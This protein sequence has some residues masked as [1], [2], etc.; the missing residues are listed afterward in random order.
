MPSLLSRPRSRL[1]VPTKVATNAGR[2]HAVDLTGGG[3]LLEPAGV[4]HADPVGHRERLGLVVGDEQG[5]DPELL[6]QAPD[7]DPQLGADPGVQRRQRFVEQQHAG[8]DRQGPGERDALLLAA[9]QLVGEAIGGL[10]ETDQLQQLP[11]ALAP[12]AGGAGRAS[13]ARRRRCR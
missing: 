5:G 13:A 1:T 9:R 11:G 2:G 8:F 7:L 12:I 6:L 4:H 3:E 10:A